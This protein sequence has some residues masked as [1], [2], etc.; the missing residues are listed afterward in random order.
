M[1][2]PG[3]LFIVLLTFVLIL[4]LL[5]LF[6]TK[7]LVTILSYQP[8]AVTLYGDVFLSFPLS[9]KVFILSLRCLVLKLF[10]LFHR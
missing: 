5:L 9:N 7:V 10:N 2:V 1:I 6:N 4:F 3:D 8:A